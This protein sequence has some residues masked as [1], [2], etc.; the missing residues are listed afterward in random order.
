MIDRGDKQDVA[1]GPFA[2]H[3]EVKFF[4]IEVF[5]F[6]LYFPGSCKTFLFKATA[7]AFV[8][9]APDNEA[10]RFSSPFLCKMSNLIS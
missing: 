9:I 6:S 10:A 1:P 3:E 7:V 2:S 5:Y 4:K 8:A